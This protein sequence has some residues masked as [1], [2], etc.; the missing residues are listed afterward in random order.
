VL[1][2]RLSETWRPFALFFT[3]SRLRSSIL[4][5]TFVLSLGLFGTWYFWLRNERPTCSGDFDLVISAAEIVDGLGGLPFKAD[6][7]IRN[8]RIACVG[9]FDLT[10]YP[11]V[12]N[13]SGL[14]VAPG[15]IDVHTH[16]ERNVPE[17]AS[18][19]LAPNF[20]RQGVTTLITGNCGRSFLDV[21]KF[22]KRLDTF[23]S[24]VN[25]ATLVGHNTI[26]TQVMKE[27]ADASTPE[28]LNRMK[29]LVR[30]AM[31]DG[32]LGFSTGLEYIPGA[33]A[34]TDEIVELAKTAGDSNGLYVSHIR[35]EATKGEAAIREAISIG[36]RASVPVHISH[37]KSQGPS[38]WGSAQRRLDLVKAAKESGLIV[39]LDQYPYTA[40]S[41][42]IAVLLPS[43]VSEGGLATAKHKLDE[44][45]I[46]R[47]VRDEMLTQLRALGWKDYSFAR[48][49]YYESDHSLVGLTIADIA[50]QRASMHSVPMR[51]KFTQAIFSFPHPAND[52]QELERQADTVIDIFRHGGAQMVF[53]DMSEDD[54]EVI[55]R[56]PE[57]MF[58]SDSGVREEN[59][60]SLPHPRGLGT[61]P[62][63]LGLYA[64]EKHLFSIEEAVR[65]MTSLPAATFGLKDRGQV[66][67][68]Y[69]A[70][71]VLF[72]SR[73]ILDR[74]TFEQPLK[75]PE[76]I[77]YII[78]NG[79]VVLDRQVITRSLPGMP[80]RH[81][82]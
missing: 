78:V 40:S 50:D 7:G 69:W 29:R 36:D 30:T 17:S 19:F 71:L 32:A 70:D 59:S 65:R 48:V 67:E 81:Y 34:S 54:V 49:A 31:N 20:V 46:Y 60:N 11:H 1:S 18:P 77:H 68:G 12:I 33:F 61:F 74:A 37:F 22:F 80:I 42:G 79:S 23:G 62:K 58:G 9:T 24:Q 57:V 73:R 14:T 39:S 82:R 35:N 2:I 5:G 28:Q 55:M 8:K 51:P 76:G 45:A 63:I 66:R 43:W 64:R 3:G 41:T 44:P 10:K 25:V 56:N 27:S 38:Q 53:F 4:V 13:G 75:A 26:R 47:R 15:F 72:D 21:G 6:I 16:I 52:Q